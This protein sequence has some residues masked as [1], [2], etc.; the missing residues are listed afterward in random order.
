M[1]QHLLCHK[2]NLITIHFRYKRKGFTYQYCN[3]MTYRSS[4]VKDSLSF[5]HLFTVL[6]LDMY[7]ECSIDMNIAINN[8]S[9]R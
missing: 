4:K 3:S 9:L 1:L 6:M 2:R 8:P 7:L 5:G